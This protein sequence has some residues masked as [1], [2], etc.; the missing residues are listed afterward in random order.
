MSRRSVLHVVTSAERRGAETFAVALDERLRQMAWTSRTVSLHEGRNPTLDLPSL[1]ESS[2]GIRTLRHLRSAARDADVVVAHGSSTL[3]ACAIALVGRETPFVYRNIG[4]PTYWS[5][6]VSAR[7]RTALCLRRAA[8][9]V[10]LT[11]RSADVLTRQFRVPS[12]RVDVIPTGVSAETFRPASDDERARARTTLRLP[13][14]APIAA[15]IGALSPEKDV[16][17]ALGAARL[18]PDIELL[19][20]GDGPQREAL[21]R[22]AHISA[23]GRVHFVGATA[24]PTVAFAAADCIVLSSQ[25]E[26]LPAVLIEAGLCGLPVASCNVGY[27]DDI[28]LDGVTGAL[29]AT[30]TADGLAKA[31]RRAMILGPSA[32]TAA[33]ERCL[34]CFEMDRIVQR[35]NHA[36]QHVLEN[37]HRTR[38]S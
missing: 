30:R 32:G 36:L 34:Q 23:P 28:V 19:V 24:E 31:L 12:D 17:L 3:P 4:D 13:Q 11:D 38:R 7:L 25:T 29:A 9:V 37:G 14:D 8:G 1:G 5:S 33:R 10:A 27:V 2:L 15:V 18:L 35:W 16:D 26:G 21:E 22:S 20:V 6:N